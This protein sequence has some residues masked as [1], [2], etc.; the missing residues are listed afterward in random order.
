[1]AAGAVRQVMLRGGCLCCR[2]LRIAPI[3]TCGGEDMTC[4]GLF[5]KQRAVRDLDRAKFKF[6][7]NGEIVR[8]WFERGLQG[9]DGPAEHC[10]EPFIFIWISLN[11]WGECTTGQGSDKDWV[12]DLAQ[13]P[14]LNR[15]FSQCLAAPQS[16]VKKAA[17]EFRRYWPIPS[18]QDW[19]RV[20]DSRPPSQAAGNSA[21]FFRD[22]RIRYEPRCALRHIEAAQ[23]IPLDWVHFLPAVYRVRCNLFHGEKNPLHPVD[24]KIVRASLAALAEFMRH[25][26]W[27]A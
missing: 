15:E 5:K 19:R 2:R 20:G 26:G 24:L 13:D 10:F 23:E 25:T 22:N 7:P 17:E 12:Q 11:A 1:M 6:M 3:H 27:F 14:G 8:H 18:V 4:P 21:R 16:A 9:I